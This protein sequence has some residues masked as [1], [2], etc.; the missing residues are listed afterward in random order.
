MIITDPSALKKVCQ[1]HRNV[2]FRVLPRHILSYLYISMIFHTKRLTDPKSSD[3]LEI[4][5][6]HPPI[7]MQGNGKHPIYIIT[8]WIT[9][10]STLIMLP[11]FHT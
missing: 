2:F 8:L 10:W 7:S 4:F 3:V 5:I 6:G 9:V 1:V 11:I